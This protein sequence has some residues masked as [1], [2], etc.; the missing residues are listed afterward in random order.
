MFINYLS[1]HASLQE[2]D[3]PEHPDNIPGYVE[4]LL[5]ADVLID[6]QIWPSHPAEIPACH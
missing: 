1:I 3:A 5:R 6:A 4:P 2:N